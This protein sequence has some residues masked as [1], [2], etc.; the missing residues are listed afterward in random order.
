MKPRIYLAGPITGLTFDEV[1]GWRE[2]VQR[3][4]LPE[5]ESDNP[6]SGKQSLAGDA[7]LTDGYTHDPLITDK[8]IFA[9]DYF[10]IR[11]ANLLFVNFLGAK[12]ISQGTNYEIAWAYEL[13]KPVLVVMEPQG[14]PHEH[15][16]LREAAAFRTDNLPEACDMVRSILLA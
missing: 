7:L 9:R 12:H 3:I 10:Y 8:A 14:N 16:F 1:Y 11:R 6:L 13:R 15:L 2:K 5:I 4:L